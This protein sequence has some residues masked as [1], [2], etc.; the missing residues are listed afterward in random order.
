MKGADRF[1]PEPARLVETNEPAGALL[2][3]SLG[4]YAAGLDGQRA[5]A[6]AQARPSRGARTSWQVVA[7]A[8]ACAAGI[9]LLLSQ[10]TPQ[11][12]VAAPPA[13]ASAPV[14]EPLK[15]PVALEAAPDEARTRKHRATRTLV[16]Q[17]RPQ[18]LE[19]GE[20][21]ALADGSRVR[22]AE[23]GAAV[24]SAPESGRTVVA[25]ARGQVGVSV[26]KRRAGERFEV[27]AGR[28]AFRVVGTRFTVEIA[29]GAARLAVAEGVVVVTDGDLE[30][31]RFVAGETWSGSVAPPAPSVEAP[32]EPPAVEPAR[33]EPPRDTPP[34]PAPER[35]LEDA[36]APA[37][38]VVR[39]PSSSECLRQSRAGATRQAAECLAAAATQR[40]LDAE[41][42][43]VELARLRRDAL[44]D[45][46]GALAALG[47]YRARFPAG[48]LYEEAL[49]ASVDLLVR[50]GDGPGAL[51]E[52]ERLLRRVGSAQRRAEL[53]LLR[54]NVLRVLQSD[55]RRA[56]AEYA[57]A[58]GTG[59]ERV[60]DDA[61]FWRAVCLSSAGEREAA[62]RAFA[63]YL[64]R[65]QAQHAA[66]AK[67]RLEGLRR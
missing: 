22:L 12:P 65:P 66:E 4:A 27:H 50:A 17:A 24:V 6:R 26:T 31:G 59:A 13:A 5:W 40:G 61:E 19:A 1:P 41:I 10:R 48:S 45:T 25:L 11:A 57:A 16:V 64:E 23:E 9:A 58:A 34:P 62:A 38:P 43:L 2:R 20:E 7:L 29:G 8:A 30:L 47:E 67:S 51:A 32:R 52:S 37:P 36:P 63:R 33:V 14:I 49:S 55:C 3:E 56:D 53:R 15:A 44:G 54:G 60:A 35:L 21:I 18:A 42:A 39:V 28:Y 46:R